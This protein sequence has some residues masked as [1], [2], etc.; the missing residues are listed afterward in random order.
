LQKEILRDV[1]PV[2]ELFSQLLGRGKPQ[3]AHVRQF[4]SQALSVSLRK[5]HIHAITGVI[6]HFL[7]SVDQCDDASW[8]QYAEGLAGLFSEALCH[9]NSSLHSCSPVI[10]ENIFAIAVKNPSPRKDT[11]I[12][13]MI[14]SIMYHTRSNGVTLLMDQLLPI[15]KSNVEQVSL[16]LRYCVEGV[17]GR[18]ELSYCDLVNE[19]FSTVTS[20]SCTSQTMSFLALIF[21]NLSY[22]EVVKNILNLERLLLQGHVDF[23]LVSQFYIE[24]ISLGPEQFKAVFS[25]FVTFLNMP[26][27]SR[28]VHLGQGLA[29]VVTLLQDSKQLHLAGIIS[30]DAWTRLITTLGLPEMMSDDNDVLKVVACL[31]VIMELKVCTP[32]T[33]LILSKGLSFGKS[34]R[35]LLARSISLAVKLGAVDRDL[36]SLLEQSPVSE[37][38]YLLRS[39]CDLIVSQSDLKI[40]D[41]P[42]WISELKVFSGSLHSNIRTPVLAAL[43][44]L[45]PEEPLIALCSEIES[46]TSSLD[47]IREKSLLI[48]NLGMKLVPSVSPIVKEII[49]RFFFSMYAINF[50][51]LWPSLDTVLVRFSELDFSTFWQHIS[52]MLSTFPEICTS[53]SQIQF[54]PSFAVPPLSDCEN[55]DY[56][57]D[58]LHAHANHVYSLSGDRVDFG[59]L[60]VHLLQ[61]VGKTKAIEVKSKYI[62]PY[63]VEFLRLEYEYFHQDLVTIAHEKASSLTVDTRNRIPLNHDSTIKVLCEFLRM[64]STVKPQQIYRPDVIYDVCQSFLLRGDPSLSKLSLQCLVTFNEE[65]YIPYHDLVLRLLDDATFKDALLSIKIDH[66]SDNTFKEHHRQ[67]MMKIVIKV[68]Y[69]RMM[70]RNSSTSWRRTNALSFLAAANDD[71]IEYLL[72]KMLPIRL[73]NECLNVDVLKLV[74]PQ[75]TLGFLNLL[76]DVIKQLHRRLACVSQEVS[77]LLASLVCSS[78]AELSRLNVED[79]MQ[80]IENV[81]EEIEVGEPTEFTNTPLNSLN[82]TQLKELRNLALRR[83][84]SMFQ[85][86]VPI[87]FKLQMPQFYELALSSRVI[88]L[89]HENKSSMS[90]ILSLLGSLAQNHFPIFSDIA[91]QVLHQVAECIGDY[92]PSRHVA[93]DIFF[94]VLEHDPLLLLDVSDSIFKNSI[95]LV[96]K[97]KV[98]SLSRVIRLCS[99]LS[100][101]I[102]PDQAPILVAILLPVLKSRASVETK[103]D[104]LSILES[105][106]THLS[107]ADT[108][109]VF[110]GVSR[111]FMEIDDLK[112][113]LR[114]VEFVVTTGNLLSL[115]DVGKICKGLNAI[116]KKR[117]GEPDYDVILNAFTDLTSKVAS[118]TEVA[119]IPILYNLFYYVR[120]S[121]LSVRANASHIIRSFVKL[122]PGNSEFRSSV[123][124]LVYPAVKRGLSS[125]SSELVKI[126]W[127]KVLAECVSNLDL[128]SFVDLKIFLP[129]DPTDESGVFENIYHIQSHRRLRALARLRNGV[130]QIRAS[131]LNYLCYPI[132]AHLMDNKDG[133]IVQE[134]A[135]TLTSIVSRLH[136]GSYYSLLRSKFTA[137][138]KEV[139]P[140]REK[141]LMKTVVALLNGFHFDLEPSSSVSASEESMLDEPSELVASHLGDMEVDD[142]IET[143]EVVQQMCTSVD[144]ISFSQLKKIKDAVTF[145]ILPELYRYLISRT[146]KS[147]N[148]TVRVRVPIALGMTRVILS[149]PKAEKEHQIPCLLTKVCQLMRSRSQATRNTTRGTLV[150]MM[151]LLGSKYLYFVIK[152]LKSALTRGYELHVLGYTVHS[153]LANLSLD[154][155]CITQCGKDLI[156]V[157][158]D[159]IFGEVGLE[160]ETEAYR[161]V[162]KELKSCT[163]YGSIEILFSKCS[164][165]WISQFLAY[166]KSILCCT[167][168]QSVLEKVS[169]TFKRACTGINSNGSIPIEDYLKLVFD[170]ISNQV[171]SDSLNEGKVAY[172]NANAHYMVEFGLQLLCLSLKRDRICFDSSQQLSMLNSLVDAVGECFGSKHDVTLIHAAKVMCNLARM[173][174]SSL[175]DTLPLVVSDTFAR[176]GEMQDMKSELARAY[177]KFILVVM[178][179]CHAIPF[180]EKQAKYLIG[181]LRTEIGSGEQNTIIYSIMRSIIARKIVI[182][183]VYIVTQ[184][185]AQLMVTSH[186][187]NVQ[188]LCRAVYV[189]FLLDYPQGKQRMNHHIMWMVK[190]LSYTFEQG[191]IS[192][193]ELINQL[194]KKVPLEMITEYGEVLL[195]GLI[196]RLDDTSSKCREMGTKTIEQLFSKF[197]NIARINMMLKSWYS[198]PATL[199]VALQVHGILLAANRASPELLSLAV[200]VLSSK[201][202]FEGETESDSNLED[203][204]QKSAWR[205]HYLAILTLSKYLQNETSTLLLKPYVDLLYPYI[206]HPHAWIRRATSRLYGVLFVAQVEME[207]EQIRLI[208]KQMSQQLTSEFLTIDLAAEITRNLFHLAKCMQRYTLTTSTNEKAKDKSQL[209][210]ECK[211]DCD[212]ESAD[213]SKSL[214][215][216]TPLLSLVKFL[217]YLARKDQSKNKTTL[218][219]RTIFQIF[220]AIINFFDVDVLEGLVNFVLAPIFRTL[221]D[222]STKGEEW[223]TCLHHNLLSICIAINVVSRLLIKGV[224]YRFI[225]IILSRTGRIDAVKVR[226]YAIC[227]GLR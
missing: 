227:W 173:P 155:S 72:A 107:L 13:I 50:A 81:P 174:I 49:C 66:G 10:L 56:F 105:S 190:N 162:M 196:T 26:V 142:V 92:E 38:P 69:G 128:D 3:K 86:N 65:W 17:G 171:P 158:T 163:S 201:E 176:L 93:L 94:S 140:K 192:V 36:I 221:H 40:L 123:Q 67:D 199:Q 28:C 129:R 115:P 52:N 157:I 179:F 187:E 119:W 32:D 211:V 122:A 39:I 63:F 223:G 208:S 117:M 204:T 170:L 4:A 44:A 89:V 29:T 20:S 215:T 125:R 80:E 152:E 57:R 59:N 47:H 153:L 147:D 134:A 78:C 225:K 74:N 71:E 145:K 75:K 1:I 2:F 112:A 108:D 99:G 97:Y 214:G 85:L 159:D 148:E 84:I 116:S 150:M 11:V 87:N 160:K 224:L 88:S 183:D 7:E 106:V 21:S 138:R 121:D 43:A 164:N 193:L 42:F 53:A 14:K 54:S 46:V 77:D 146:K 124:H 16:Y 202:Q 144:T 184:E 79:T 172:W 149:L 91:S 154:A 209:K 139:E 210:S 167:H 15:W 151:K 178:R 182:N 25:S 200:N 8:N 48:K 64:F 33:L 6:D 37:C 165:D 130:N 161:K 100:Q 126:E 141:C 55:V 24:L 166:I 102:R 12:S 27:A 203:I 133:N 222:D 98:D 82:V 35:F 195:V 109:S 113:R 131:T 217:S 191:R 213:E 185:M 132:V 103:S 70:H 104:I 127:V 95:S 18:F 219:R 169:R 83:L 96:E 226:R 30:R 189:Q 137:L 5:V 216:R 34:N 156:Q 135:V 181:I 110:R 62:M 31:S 120:D 206:L 136:W 197:P 175:D 41:V 51:P 212:S 45:M 61:L 90:P 168:D 114:I 186:S 22:H 118:L 60:F 205:V 218:L 194:I 23:N 58:L 9:V 220:A 76:A 101:F 19:F 180:T 198:N 111:L 143:D 177:L 207:L 73:E 68:L 188:D